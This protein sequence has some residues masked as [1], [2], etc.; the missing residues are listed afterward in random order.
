MRSTLEP[1]LQARFDERLASTNTPTILDVSKMVV[2]TFNETEEV[3][4]AELFEK[5]EQEDPTLARSLKMIT[6]YDKASGA[7]P[8]SLLE[9]KDE[10]QWMREARAGQL[11][12]RGDTWLPGRQREPENPELRKALGL[13]PLEGSDL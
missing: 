9:L 5:L 10:L 11:D 12:E 3:R 4:I 1:A 7:G 8:T 6:Q 13:D 2:Q